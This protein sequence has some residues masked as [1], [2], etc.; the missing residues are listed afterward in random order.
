MLLIEN[1]SILIN[2]CAQLELQR[3]SVMLSIV[4]SMIRLNIQL[5]SVR[6]FEFQFNLMGPASIYVMALASTS[7]MS[8][9]RAIIHNGAVHWLVSNAT[10][11]WVLGRQGLT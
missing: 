2:D 7:A 10:D 4:G 8:T 5:H 6:M 9:H 11:L 3:P 1:S